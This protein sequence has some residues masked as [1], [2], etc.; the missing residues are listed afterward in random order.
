VGQSVGYVWQVGLLCGVDMSTDHQ[1]VLPGAAEQLAS[2]G[3][4]Y[5]VTGVQVISGLGLG[6]E[7]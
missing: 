2:A 6:R 1:V 7:T 5:Q 3:D 4:D